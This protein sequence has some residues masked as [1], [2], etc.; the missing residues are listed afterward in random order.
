MLLIFSARHISII[1]LYLFN[2]FFSLLFVCVVFFS[3]CLFSPS[4]GPDTKHNTECEFR[5]IKSFFYHFVY[6]VFTTCTRIQHDAI[7]FDKALCLQCIV[8]SLILFFVAS[9]TQCIIYLKPTQST[10]IARLSVHHKNSMK[11]KQRR[12]KEKTSNN[13]AKE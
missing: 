8:F 3:F 13:N 10:I 7:G 11:K 1:D 9:L 4:H 2:S 5:F 12:D 6:F